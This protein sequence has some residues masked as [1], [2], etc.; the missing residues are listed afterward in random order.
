MH[1]LHELPLSGKA[2]VVR[3]SLSVVEFRELQQSIE[4]LAMLTEQP[5]A[6]V[7]ERLLCS[8]HEMLHGKGADSFLALVDDIASE[9]D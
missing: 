8:Y 3:A 2:S 5:V 7:A 9:P 4:H 6:D 1:W